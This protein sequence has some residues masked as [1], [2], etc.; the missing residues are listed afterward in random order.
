MLQ[1]LGVEAE[2][3]HLVSI[4]LSRRVSKRRF[5]PV[6]QR[7]LF[8]HLGIVTNRT[9]ETFCSDTVPLLMLPEQLIESIYG[10]AARMLALG[11]DIAAIYRMSAPP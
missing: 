1:R 3:Q 8:N 6:I 10:P 9:F 11:D 7:P 2:R 5:S 4:R